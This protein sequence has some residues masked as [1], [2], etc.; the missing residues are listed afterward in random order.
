MLPSSDMLRIKNVKW[1]ET[2]IGNIIFAWDPLL[3]FV[4]WKQDNL[5]K[6][7]MEVQSVMNSSRG[8]TT[9]PGPTLQLENWQAEQPLSQSQHH[10]CLLSSFP[11]TRRHRPKSFCLY[12]TQKLVQR[13][14]WSGKVSSNTLDNIITD[15]S[16]SSNSTKGIK[17]TRISLQG[18]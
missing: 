9:I 3:N 16:R 13:N 12:F 5:K 7:Y 14:Q 17:Q 15:Q 8:N 10:T 6:S 1:M 18:V 2:L 4:I 11:S